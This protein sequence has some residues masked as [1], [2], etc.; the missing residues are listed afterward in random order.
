M[1][2]TP[3]R[4]DVHVD[5][6]EKLLK[7]Y[8]EESQTKSETEICRNMLNEII[9]HIETPEEKHIDKMEVGGIK[10]DIERFVVIKNGEEISL[11]KKE[12]KL[13]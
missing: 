13:L 11:P 7:R 8:Y 6:G 1:G 3:S 10:I 12:F 4:E 2:L 9:Q 5:E